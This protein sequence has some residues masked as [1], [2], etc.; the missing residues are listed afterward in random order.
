MHIFNRTVCINGSPQSIIN[1]AASRMYREKTTN[2][3][4]TSFLDAIRMR[5]S[6]HTIK[7]RCGIHFQ[8]IYAQTSIV[9][10]SIVL[11]VLLICL[12]D[13]IYI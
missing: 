8:Q 5:R 6:E 11:N 9:L 10:P 12:P 1:G 13:K 7:L 2:A 3:T 4:R